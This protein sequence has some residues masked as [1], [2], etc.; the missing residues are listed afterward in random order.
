MAVLGGPHGDV[1]GHEHAAHD[2]VN[3]HRGSRV[4]VLGLVLGDELLGVGGDVGDGD[5]V[6]E[7]LGDLLHL[8]GAELAQKLGHGRRLAAR[9]RVARRRDH[10]PNIQPTES[11]GSGFQHFWP[12]PGARKKKDRAR[13]TH[14]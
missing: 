4:D 8:K 12:G 2:V 9:V 10:E 13:Q 5:L 1:G 3:R 14:E 11:R 7:E 6:L